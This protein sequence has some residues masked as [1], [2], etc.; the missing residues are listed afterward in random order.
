MKRILPFI[1]IPLAAALAF[2]GWRTFFGS[3]GPDIEPG[4]TLLVE[5]S[6]RY[7]EAPAQ[8]LISRVLGDTERPFVGLLSTLALAERDDR[9]ATVVLRI[10]SLDIGWGKADELRAAIGRL[11]AAGRKTVAYLELASFNASREYYVATAADEI[12][13]LP[14]AAIPVVG[15][16]AE[17]IFL[18]G[19]WEKLGLEIEVS[20][21]GK[22]KSAVE[23]IAGTGMSEASREMANSLLDDMDRRF[24]TAIAQGRGLTPAT[25]DAVIDEGPVL[26]AQL[27]AHD[28]I[29][30]V[31]HLRELAAFEAPV[32]TPEVYA[33]VSPGDLGFE[34]VA[35][36]ALVYG[37]GT[38]VAGKGRRSLR[39]E[40]VFASE[41]VSQALLDAAKDPEIDG[42]VFR[43]DSPGGT[44]FAPEVI[45][46]AL[47]HIRA[48]G[49]K[50][51]VASFSDVAASAGYYAAVGADAIVSSPG[52]LTGSIGVFALR[53]VFG[54][55]FDKLGI[56]VETL[57]RGKH[58]DFLLSSGVQSEGSR[59]RMRALT[60]DIYDLFVGRVA[61]GRGLER[62]EVDAVGQGRV[63]TGE[64]A[65]QAGLVDELGGLH[66]AVSWLNRE[67]GHDED[68]D[69]LL[70]PYPRTGGLS[71]Q[72]AELLRGDASAFSDLSARELLA[73]RRVLPLPKILWQLESWLAELPL[74]APL[75]IPPVIVEIH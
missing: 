44:S 62:I 19:V 35:H 58:A 73:A 57:Q 69:V 38:V 15:L 32:V 9:I 11:R 45:W 64:Q 13:V 24:R 70:I 52:T 22:Y 40:P 26:P 34:P 37:S 36:F 46:S 43:I 4:S 29:D 51:V 54:G 27:V 61:E 67:L 39:G 8:P 30:G 68:A 23:T 16:A 6:G 21:A 56:E 47:Q 18:G 63:W 71:E 55:L 12:Y 75:L 41:T 59:E 33:E 28:F 65:H 50:P 42:I 10:R 49:A 3:G 53:P 72:I 17:Y 2:A 66:T 20:R 1:V 31:R 25:V 5:L 74:D 60:L 48:E 7:V 14:G